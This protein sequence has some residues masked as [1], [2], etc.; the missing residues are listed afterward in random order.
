MKTDKSDINS[1]A[2]SPRTTFALKVLF[3]L[4]FATVILVVIHLVLQY[5]NLKVFNERNGQIFELSNRFDL[6]DEASVPTWFSQILFL[7][8]SFSAFLAGWLSTKKAVKWTWI[9]IGTGGLLASID[10]I[11]M[12]HEFVLQSLHLAFF[13]EASP[14]STHNAW[15]LVLP[16]ILAIF[17]WLS[18]KMWQLLPRRT[19]LILV[20]AGC[21]FLFGAAGIDM[22][23]SVSSRTTYLYQGLYVAVEESLELLG[24][25]IALYGIV[26]YIERKHGSVIKQATKSLKENRA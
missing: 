3:V 19:F 14:T 16:I 17:G 25:V 6:D 26:D 9:T 5:L 22:I 10:E 13:K 23:A 7:A 8:I 24:S 12:L 4:L 18:F 2:I 1:N 21:V 20:F 15:L 11:S